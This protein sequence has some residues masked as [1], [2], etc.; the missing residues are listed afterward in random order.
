MRGGMLLAL[1]LAGIGAASAVDPADL[2]P[3]DEAFALR[4]SAPERGRIEL[5]WRIADGYYMYRHRMAAQPVAAAPGN[6]AFKAGPLQLPPGKAYRDPFFGDVQTYR[7]RVTAVLTGVAAPGA[8]TVTLQ[9]KSQGC[10]DLG[11]CYPPQTRT[12]TVRLPATSTMAETTTAA[13]PSQPASRPEGMTVGRAEAPALVP[14]RTST[15][16]NGRVITASAGAGAGSGN[17]ASFAALSRSLG[18]GSAAPVRGVVPDPGSKPPL[19]PPEQAF[20][21]E[22][23][24]GDGNTLLLRF[25]PARG[26]NLYRDRTTLKLDGASG[27]ALGPARWPKGTVHRDEFFGTMVV[28]S[29]QVD[30]RVPLRR[31]RTEATDLRLAATFQGCQD[32]GICYPPMTRTVAIALPAGQVTALGD[33]GAGAGSGPA[34]TATSAPILQPSFR[35]DGPVAGAPAL[36]PADAPTSGS[37]IS[38]NASDAVGPTGGFDTGVAATNAIAADV[39]T[40]N[41]ANGSAAAASDGGRAED[42]RLAA[43]LQG[44]DRWW[45]L[46]GFL[47]A[48][49]LLAFTPCV[50]P[51]I[52]ILSGLIAG[53]GTRIGTRRA[54]LLSLVYV[55]ATALV[56]TA[57][58]VV[59][60]LVGAN[61][62]AT[63][64]KPWVIVAFA[65]MFVLL[66][67][68]SFGLFKLQLPARLR[69]RLAAIGDRQRGGSLAGVA[70]MGVLSALIVGPC[71]APP[72]AAAVLYIGQTRDPVFG[73][74]ALFLLAMG[75]GLPLLAFGAAAGRGMPTSGPWMLAAQRVFG[76]V[77][78]GLAVW[79]LSRILPGTLA[80]AAWGLLALAA[81][82]WAFSA[83]TSAA[84]GRVRLV[85]RFAGLVLAVVGAA[86][87]LGALGGGRDPLQPLAGIVGGAQETRKL[88][89]RPV[90]TAADVDR[91]LAAAQA[92]GTPLLLDFYADWCAACKQM[93]KYTF[94]DPAVNDALTGFVL[95]KADVTANDAADQALLQ[96][97]R[98]IGPPAALFFADG[99]ERRE[100]RLIGFEP[101]APFAARVRRVGKD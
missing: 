49:L 100:L 85:A 48:G 9:V 27:I 18:A 79:M 34:L 3:V 13:P 2:L 22:A 45:A 21:F 92:A 41:P 46:L 71:V 35:P 80:L 84:H 78:L 23:I 1:A 44:T 59:A 88:A 5:T 10:A 77:F 69:A 12:V 24:A 58:G 25:T 83:A 89:F 63:F 96:R 11:V 76:F 87:L 98:L 31:T 54:L 37:G 47:G 72:L 14:G 70:T 28:Y 32:E 15:P 75:M 74:A 33:A 55:V 82:A 97:Y 40:G 64:Q 90:K 61:L 19:L 17:D 38:G 68:S 86:E 53:Q 66:A 57:A 101:A 16:T 95:L 91:E 62:Q 51:M 42:T 52:P 4:A 26:Y 65:A 43:A 81:A 20:G 99:R 29:D 60:G 39:A 30:V 6:N 94:A 7:D 8:Q 73:G 56:F 93:Q 67:L 50:L 36:G